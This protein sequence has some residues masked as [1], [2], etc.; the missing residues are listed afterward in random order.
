MRDI[1][2]RGRTVEGKEWV[3][4]YFAMFSSTTFI[5]APN[6]HGTMLWFEVDP[7]TVGQFTGTTDNIGMMIFEHDIVRCYGPRWSEKE[8]VGH[9]VYGDCCFSVKEDKKP[10]RP[11]MDL[12]A[13]FKVIGTIHDNPELMEVQH[14]V[15]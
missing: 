4:G 12:C 10:N 11:A 8:M 5:G 6:S 2:F 3:N 13:D 7:D 1:L 15:E 9:I 14:E